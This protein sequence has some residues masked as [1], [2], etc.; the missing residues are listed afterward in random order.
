MT[1]TEY[2]FRLIVGTAWLV[3]AH[4]AEHV[5]EHRWAY[6]FLGA[7]LFLLVLMWVGTDFSNKDFEGRP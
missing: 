6:A 1:T 7:C 5:L 4:F 2:W 3:L